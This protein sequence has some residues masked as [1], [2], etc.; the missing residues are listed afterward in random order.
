MVTLIGFAA[1]LFLNLAENLE[2]HASPA[3]A[4][5]LFR[6]VAQNVCQRYAGPRWHANAL[7]L[8]IRRRFNV[9]VSPQWQRGICMQVRR[10][11]KTH[12]D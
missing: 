12:A 8:G 3:E 4:P 1:W 2:E 6:T 9:G 10:H 5:H 11:Y 7:H